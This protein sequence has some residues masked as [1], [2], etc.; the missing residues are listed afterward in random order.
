[1]SGSLR[2][3][4][5]RPDQHDAAEMTRRGWWLAVLSA[6]L[7]G[8]AQLVAGSRILARIGLAAALVFYALAITGLVLSANDRS[9]LL[10]LLAA[11]TALL[12]LQWVCYALAAVWV[13]IQLDTIRL[14]RLVRVGAG[15][16]LWLA[17]VLVGVLVLPAAGMAVAGNYAGSGRAAIGEVFA[18]TVLEEPVDGRYNILLLG[19]DAGKD[20]LG[21]RPDS[22]SV[23]SIDAETGQTAIIGIPRNLERIPFA[24][25]S[26]L[27]G[28][29]P[30]GYD[31]GDECLIH[32]LYPY[33]E[34]RPALYP[35]AAARGSAPGVEAM[36]DAVEGVLGI[37]VQY[38]VVIEMGGFAE[39]IDALGGIEIEVQER[40]D[41]GGWIK[42]GQVVGVKGWFEPG[43]Q[44]LGG[45]DALYYVRSRATTNDFSRM[46]RQR[47]VQEAM[48]RQFTPATVLARFEA[49]A[50]AGS[51]T[52]VSDIPAAMLGHFAELALQAK[53]L[54]VLRL[55][56]TPPEYSVV[57]PEYPA[58]RAAVAALLTPRAPVPL[59]PD[60][61]ED[62]SRG[63][64]G[65]T[66]IPG[67]V[68]P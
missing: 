53:A 7:P 23:V 33:A 41:K 67:P 51:R 27:W 26:P 35:Q 48:L 40:I 68:I 16:R 21:L 52:V 57:D 56:V 3:P 63:S 9:A 1:M 43:L 62:D 8:S 39:L 66:A 2:Q 18:G 32:Y 38:A 10:G 42:D 55:E 28:E 17:G 54:E 5:R 37:T 60:P 15:A 20:R 11:P 36:R 6:L 64:R 50:A 49:I 22:I 46:Q 45:K 19:G 61:V 4:I 34:E 14:V 29:F 25:G 12:V 30:N 47:Q 59:D 13:L 58:I 31:C 24:K 44:R 65:G